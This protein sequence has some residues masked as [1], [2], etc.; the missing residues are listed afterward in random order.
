VGMPKWSEA[1]QQFARAFQRAHGQAETGLV[2]T[3]PERLS[4][5]ES[6][7]DSEKTG[8]GSDDIGDIMWGVPTARLSFPSNIPGA[9]G[10]HWTSAVSMA[11]PVAHKGATAVRLLRDG[12][13][14][15]ETLQ[16]AAQ[17]RRQ[18]RDLAKQVDDGPVQAGVAEVLLRSAAL[19]DVPGAARRGV[20]SANAAGQGSDAAAIARRL[21]KSDRPR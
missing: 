8:G 5:R 2:T 15:T 9:T 12:P 19:Q 18:A 13:A 6:I 1:D 16:A 4:G 11:T 20:S 21:R 3:V 10:H 14:G 7:P 17:A